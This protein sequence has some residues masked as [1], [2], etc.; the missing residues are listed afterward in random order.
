MLVPTLA[1]FNYPLL[2]DMIR[3]RNIPQMIS[4]YSNQTDFNDL[5]AENVAKLSVRYEPQSYTISKEKK[6]ITINHLISTLGGHLHLFLGMSLMSFLE[7]VELAVLAI[8]MIFNHR[9]ESENKNS[10]PDI[11]NIPTP[12]TSPAT[13][14]VQ[15]EIYVVQM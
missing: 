10:T 3:V 8:A 4:K 6:T 14:A 15:I 11:H 2:D 5:L 9:K 12:V 1:I 13:R 7:L